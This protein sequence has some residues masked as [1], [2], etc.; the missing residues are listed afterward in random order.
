MTCFNLNDNRTIRSFGEAHGLDVRTDHR[1]LSRPVLPNGLAAMNV[2]AVHAVRPRHIIGEH[3]K[4]TVKV[5][6]VESIVHTLQNFN[7]AVHRIS[8]FCSSAE[9]LVRP[10]HKQR[11]AAIYGSAELLPKEMPRLT[12]ALSVVRWGLS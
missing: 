3:G 12:G 6:L 11:R 5:S 2:A 10:S 9:R 7:I 4:H 8:S 1:P